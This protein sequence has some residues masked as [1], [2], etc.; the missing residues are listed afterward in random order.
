VDKHGLSSGGDYAASEN[1][2]QETGHF[3]PIVEILRPR[4][5]TLVN[6]I[7]RALQFA[8]SETRGGQMKEA[9]LLGSIASWRGA[10]ELLSELT[11]LHVRIPPSLSKEE[12]IATDSTSGSIGAVIATGLALR[13]MPDDA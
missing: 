1:P 3:S 6:E 11:D 7:R 8:A 2:L 5:R 12:G 10:T 4:F 9:F 13:G